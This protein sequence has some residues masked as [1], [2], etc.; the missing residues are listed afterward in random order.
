MQLIGLH[1]TRHYNPSLQGYSDCKSAS[2]QIN[3][4]ISS[5]NDKQHTITLSY[6]CNEL[7]PVGQWHIRKS[8]DRDV[9][10]PDHIMRY[11]H[12]AQLHQYLADQN[13]NMELYWQE[14][15]LALA[16]QVN[17]PTGRSR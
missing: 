4:I 13:G 6:I 1:L 5:H 11:Q 10:V 2:A 9:S 12:R 16:E 17:K 15:S 3:T 7:I 14:F 8:D